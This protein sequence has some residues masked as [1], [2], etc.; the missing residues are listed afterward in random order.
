MFCEG[1]LRNGREKNFDKGVSWY[2]LL[3]CG[4]LKAFPTGKL[5]FDRRIRQINGCK[6]ESKSFAQAWFFNIIVDVFGIDR[7]FNNF[8]DAEGGISGRIKISRLFME[9][10]LSIFPPVE[11]INLNK[12]R[13]YC[14]SLMAFRNLDNSTEGWDDVDVDASKVKGKSTRRGRRCFQMTFAYEIN[15]DINKKY[16]CKFLI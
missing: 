13:S 2:M 4:W 8:L 10:T 16:F 5:I 6:S 14:G 9:D 11:F 15:Y 1:G 7:V 12:K 3:F